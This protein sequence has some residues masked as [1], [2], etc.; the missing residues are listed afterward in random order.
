MLTGFEALKNVGDDAIKDILNKRPFTSFDDFMLR[1]DFSKMRS[2]TIQALAVSGCLDSF[3]IPRHLIF[4]YCSDYKK[5]LQV[6]LKKHNPKLERFEYP[7]PVEKEWS[8]PELYALEKE[9]MG[10]AFI[11][12]KEEA[13]VGFFDNKIEKSFNKIRQL[14]NKASIQD[15][16]AEV[17]D[18]FLLKVKK[19]GSKYLGQDMVK[20][21]IEDQWNEQISLTIFPDTWKDIKNIIKNY[22]NKYRFDEGLAINFSGSVNH[23]G[24]EI[25]IVLEN[26]HKFCPAPVAP[27]NLKAKKVVKKISSSD[28]VID[29]DSNDVNQLVEDLEDELFNE[30]LIDLN[31]ENDN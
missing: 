1:S 28:I 25:G 30:G 31:E 9:C 7:W 18:I 3:N 22:G 14:D 11:C 27:K 26:F 24:D 20:A 6:W 5:K 2:N 29:N 12:G 15:I 16:K 8:K 13:Y 23:Y 17:K 10:E 21:T 4:L 19:E